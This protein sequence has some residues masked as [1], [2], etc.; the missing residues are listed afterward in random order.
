[1]LVVGRP[2][3]RATDPAAAAN[4]ILEEIRSATPLP[5]SF[6]QSIQK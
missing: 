2:I 6:A 5:S 1:M 3:T 4:R